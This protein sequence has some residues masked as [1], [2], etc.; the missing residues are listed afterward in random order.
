MATC[1]GID[2]AKERQAIIGKIN[3]T[4]Q[5][6]EDRKKGDRLNYYVEIELYTRKSAKDWL[7][8]FKKWLE[9]RGESISSTDYNIVLEYNY[10]KEKSFSRRWGCFTCGFQP[11]CKLAEALQWVTKFK[12]KSP[13]SNRELEEAVGRR[14]PVFL[15]E[16]EIK[17][18]TVER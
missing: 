12:N 14:C 4:L 2:K 15:D 1:A 6:I 16:D 18:K 7:E 5:L 3:D 17:R 10:T 11:F 8:D 9:S 13:F